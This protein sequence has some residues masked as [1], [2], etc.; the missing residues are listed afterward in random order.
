MKKLKTRYVCQECGYASVKLYGRCPSCGSWNSMVEE[1]ESPKVQSVPSTSEPIPLHMWEE[2]KEERRSSGFPALDQALGGGLVLGQVVLIAGE[3]GI[4]KSTLLLQVCDRFS[5][6]EGPVL[7]VSGEESGRQISL[8]AKRLNIRSENLYLYTE[9]NLSKIV[10]AIQNM[11]PSLVVIDSIQT[12][13]SELLESSAGSVAQV[14]E[15]AFKIAEVCKGL[16]IPV[17]IVGQITKEGSIAGPKVLEHLVDTVLSFEGERFNFYRVVKVVKNRFGSVGEMAV[18]RMTDA[19]LEEVLEP[20]AF[21]LQERVKAPGSVVFPYTEGS[22]P[23]L[24]EVQALTVDALYTTPQRKTQGFDVNRLAL[25]LAILEKEV[26]IFTR[27]KDVFINVVGGLS[28]REP[29]VD[30]AVALSVVSSVKNKAI[31]DAIIFGEL[32]LAGEVRA[33]HFSDIRLKEALRFGFKKAIVPKGSMVEVEG[34]EIYPV[35]SI[36]EAVELLF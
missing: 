16:E 30:L 1:V 3:P 36:K 25:I 14:R 19:G 34:M 31:E 12:I 33:V 11:R 27:D 17:F 15:C 22:K 23:V 24:V 2:V 8:R 13:H 26:K 7:Y 18:F 35:S 10:Q 32:G 20:S 21:F 9:T 28:L 4:G 5:K 6:E 29:A